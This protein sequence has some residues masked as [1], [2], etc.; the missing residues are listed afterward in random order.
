M[1]L[2]AIPGGL[3]VGHVKRKKYKHEKGQITLSLKATRAILNLCVC[4]CGA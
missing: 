4:V 3:K 1:H 2:N